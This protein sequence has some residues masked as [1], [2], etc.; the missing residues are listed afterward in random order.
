[1]LNKNIQKL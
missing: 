1:M